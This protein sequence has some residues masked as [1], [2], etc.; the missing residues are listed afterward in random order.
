[1][2]AIILSS[3]STDLARRIRLAT[4]KDLL[5][6]RPEQLP[7]VPAQVMAIANGSG[8]MTTLVIDPD[9]G[10]EKY[11]FDLARRFEKEHPDVSVLLVTDRA[12][13]LG[14]SALRSGMRDLIEETA[15][16]EDIRLTL[17]RAERARAAAFQS[18]KA[19]PREGA[20][21]VPAR[22]VT[23]ASPK[24]GVGKTTLATNI[25]VGL[26]QQSSQEVVL[27]DLDIQFGD[28]AAALNLEP[29]ATLADVV[30]GPALTDSMTL[31]AMLT[32]HETG[33]HV[34][35]GAKSPAEADGMT[36]AHVGQIL[37]HLAAQFRYVVIDTAP[38]LS[39]Q[40]LAALD[41]TTD[42]VVVT[43]QDVPGVRGL[44]KEL[45]L[46]D[47]LDLAPATRH[48]VLNFSDKSGG[49]SVRDVEKTIKRKVD[50]ALPRHKKVVRSTNQGVPLVLHGGRD[51]VVKELQNLAS[52]F[53]PVTVRHDGGLARHGKER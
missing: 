27:V 43:S 38:G 10:G 40:T 32:R 33:L 23:V 49:L 1:M 7:A 14:L 22:V 3:S 44:R 36:P 35:C 48:V 47:A 46:L 42:L 50:L 31:K 28:V 34:L 26:A 30:H 15:S 8:P 29:Q 17:D 9:E 5:V 24:G 6:I 20:D 37:T 53:V 12:K 4:A 13:E 45:E 18:E 11:A 2:S 41:H 19:G 52:W 39:E 16:V 21:S 25:A 51:R